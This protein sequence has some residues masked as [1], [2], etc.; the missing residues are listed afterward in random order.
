LRIL[1]RLRQRARQLRLEAVALSLAA[2]HPQTPWYAKL[3]VAAVVVYVVT[4][5]DFAPDFLPVLGFIDDLV[6]VPAALAV[7]VRFIPAPV[8][9]DC[10]GR[11]AELATRPRKGFRAW[12]SGVI[13][14]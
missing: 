6:F 7:A 11:A 2:R 14:R 12:L 5:V 9:D 13:K 10:R 4:P 3:V 1:E 8:L